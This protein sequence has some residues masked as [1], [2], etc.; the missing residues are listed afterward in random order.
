[1][2]VLVRLICA[3]KFYLLT[4]LGKT[5]LDVAPATFTAFFACYF[6][7]RLYNLDLRS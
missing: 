7:L 5:S 6:K 2:H 3:I 1:M 4:Y